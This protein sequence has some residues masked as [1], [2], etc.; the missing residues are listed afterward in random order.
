MMYSQLTVGKDRGDFTGDT[1][2]AIQAAVD[3]AASL[4]GGTV[5]ILPGRYAM[6]DSLHIRSNVAVIGAGEETVL[7]KPP[8]AT[9]PVVYYLGYGHFDVSV[10]EPDKFP[11]GCGV[12]IRDSRTPGF[13]A[14]VATVIRKSGKELGLSRMLNADVHP[15]NGARALSVYPIISGCNITHASVQDITIDGNATDNEFIDGCR[16][17]GVYLLQAHDTKL[18]NVS[19]LNYNGDGI[20]FQQCRNTVAEGCRCVG[21]TGS[22]LHPGSGSVGSVMRNCVCGNNGQNGIFYCLRVAWTLCEDCRFEGNKSHGI[23]IGHRDCDNV[24]RSNRIA[25]NGGHGVHFRADSLSQTGCRT[26][27]EGNLFHQNCR[28]GDGA[29]ICFDSSADQVHLSG[30]VFEPSGNYAHVIEMLCPQS[31][32]A[33]CGNVLNTVELTPDSMAG[34]LSGVRFGLPDAPLAA[35]PDHM[36]EDA[37]LHLNGI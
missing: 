35:G 23:S 31:N 34:D 3:R 14:T 11:V 7:W 37:A 22:G 9:S 24:I 4:G 30:N 33:L 16:G 8:S 27:L 28:A 6:Y 13:Y 21:N 17:G 19:V 2:V 10:E 32:L 29:E 5:R 36:P 25:G 15:D 26:L 20:S 18:A 12:C 1:N